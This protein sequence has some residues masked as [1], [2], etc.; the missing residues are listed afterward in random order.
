MRTYRNATIITALLTLASVIGAA[1]FN[2]YTNY[3]SFWCNL[4]LGIFGSGLVT[5]ITS[6][7]GYRV[8][9]RKTFEGFSYSTKQILKRLNKYQST[10]P[11]EQKF[12]FFLDFHDIDMG[13]W[14]QYY[15]DFCLMFDFIFKNQTYI[16]KKIYHPIQEIDQKINYHIGHFRWHKD[17]SGRNDR[18]MEKFV[19]EIE[20]LIIKTTST[21]F[22][23]FGGFPNSAESFPITQT[24]NKIVENVIQ[25]LNGEYY[26][27]MYG[28]RMYQQSKKSRI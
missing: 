21:Q 23:G 7:I 20:N 12:N 14:D 24:H 13:E 6:V 19:Q 15:G 11:L 22:D 3:N 25:E 16:F 27:L 9:R 10:W 28:K 4:L 17:G 8:E 2:F 5:F 18:V 26:R 1:Y